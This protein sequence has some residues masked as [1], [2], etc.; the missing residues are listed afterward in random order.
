[1]ETVEAKNFWII[2]LINLRFR[3]SINATQ[4]LIQIPTKKRSYPILGNSHPL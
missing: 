4:K 1:M 2:Q 3:T